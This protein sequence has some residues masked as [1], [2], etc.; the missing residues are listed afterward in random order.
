MSWLDHH[1]SGRVL[2]VVPHGHYKG[3]VRCRGCGATWKHD[4]RGV[5]RASLLCS[6]RACGLHFLHFFDR[7]DF[8]PRISRKVWQGWQREGYA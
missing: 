4:L 1:M 7:A 2:F 3:N 6:C 5:V 8:Y